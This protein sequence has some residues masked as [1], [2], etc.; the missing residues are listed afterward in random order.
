MT[1]ES[2]GSTAMAWKVALRGLMTST[3]PVIVPPVPTAATRM[4]TLPSVSSQISS[5]V[6]FSMNLRIGRIVELLRH[7]GVGRVLHQIFGARDRA[8]HA[9]GA[10]REHELG[11]EHGEQ[12]AALERHRLGHREDQLV[13]LGRGDERERDAGV[14]AGRLDDDGVLV[15]HAA[16]LRVLDHRHADAVLHAAERIEEFALERDRCASSPAVTRLSLTSGVR[17]TVSTML[18]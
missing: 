11:A 3:Q 18:L 6:V 17:P 15:Q 2:A 9:F 5:A 10:G 16:L 1:G 13:A 8:L 14:A 7:P 12:R 4:S